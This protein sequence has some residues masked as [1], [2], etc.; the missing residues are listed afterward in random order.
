MSSPLLCV[1]MLTGCFGLLHWV[2]TSYYF[3]TNEPMPSD[4]LTK[5]LQKQGWVDKFAY[6]LAG[7]LFVTWYIITPHELANVFKLRVEEWIWSGNA[8]KFFVRISYKFL[9]ARVAAMDFIMGQI[10]SDHLFDL[11]IET[12]RRKCNGSMSNMPGSTDSDLNAP[13]QSTIM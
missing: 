6:A 8:I 12:M 7:S 5:A 3:R 10:M 4:E 9:V 2:F 1:S 11:G 13:G